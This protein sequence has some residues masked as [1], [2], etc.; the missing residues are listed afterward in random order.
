LYSW[1]RPAPYLLAAGCCITGGAILLTVRYHAT[2]IAVERVSVP[3]GG[4]IREAMEGL[5]AIRRQPILL[6]AISLDLFA[7]L[8]GGAI[9]L[10][11]AIA[12]DRLNTD[13]AGLG[14]LRAAVGIGAGVV[15]I[16][17]AIRPVGRHIG[18]WL[19][20]SVAVFGVAHIGL[21]LTTSYAM[22]FGFLI[23]ASA[24]DAISVFVRATLLPLVTPNSIRGRVLAVEA[25]FIGASN[26]LGAFES[27]VAGQVLGAANAIVFGGVAT[28]VVVAI[29]WYA[30]PALRNIDRFPVAYRAPSPRADPM[31]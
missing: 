4:Q 20:A 2:D 10:L 5:R 8:F 11:P 1:S 17:L 16:A 31:P 26:E 18:R 13:A 6:G 25:V 3:K 15:T 22:A 30:F 19:F 29:W 7:V 28:L 9:A 14:W 12:T 21:G 27:G 24:F 23:V